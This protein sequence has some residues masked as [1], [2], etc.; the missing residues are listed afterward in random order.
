MA[1]DR[2]GNV[3]VTGNLTSG[4]SYD[5]ATIKYSSSVLPVYLDF[6]NLNNQ[7]VLSWT[8]NAFSLQ[9]APAINGTFTNLP[10][11]TSPFTNDL[12]VP[13]RY[14]RLILN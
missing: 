1:L 5:Y 2:S 12:T 10:G 6:L 13:E 7:L 14:F 4:G 9:S 8:N 3:F 11:A